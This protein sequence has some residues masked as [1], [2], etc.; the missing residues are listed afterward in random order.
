M[1]SNPTAASET[2]AK[3][4]LFIASAVFL[5][6]ELVFIR[7]FPA[8]V[9]FLTF[10]TNTVL[11]AS[12]IGL[13]LGCL[14]ARSKRD[15]L[16]WTP[17]LLLCCI[18]TAAAM[19]WLRL[20][21]QDVTPGTARRLQMPAGQSGAVI[22][23]VVLLSC[24]TINPRPDGSIIVP[25]HNP[26][27]RTIVGLPQKPGEPPRGFVIPPHDPAVENQVPI[28][29]IRID[30]ILAHTLRV[31]PHDPSATTVARAD[32]MSCLVDSGVPLLENL[33]LA[34][35]AQARCYESV[36][37]VLPLKVRGATASVV[38]PI[39]LA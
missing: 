19:E 21:L 12:F 11:L 34:E 4:E 3:R 20:T 33:R 37:V 8:Q 38:H 1:N 6:A 30:S 17:A 9:L 16:S 2:S 39:A 24:S 13:S 25:P 27:H 23:D 22:T 5:F 14:A 7:W 18:G 28:K 36:L 10:F 32:S 31:Q 35:M 29:V 26:R 15:Y